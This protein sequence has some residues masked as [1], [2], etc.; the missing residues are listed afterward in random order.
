MTR[1]P[2]GEQLS[3]LAR[4]RGGAVLPYLNLS[5]FAWISI[6]S[7]SVTRKRVSVVKLSRSLSMPDHR[8]LVNG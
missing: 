6:A 2:A 8:L 4:A 7:S 3:A 1:S 5:A